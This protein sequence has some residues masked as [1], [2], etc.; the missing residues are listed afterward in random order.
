MISKLGHPLTPPLLPP[1]LPP[2][3]FHG[4]DLRLLA[5]RNSTAIRTCSR[6]AYPASSPVVMSVRSVKRVAA[7]VG[8]GSM[9]I[10]FV[11]QYLRDAATSPR[12]A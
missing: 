6:Q 10:A 9:A 7:A 3:P 1:L 8:E 11:H 2:S 4:T 12:P 5:A